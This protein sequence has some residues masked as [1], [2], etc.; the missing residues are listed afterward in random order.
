M[1]LG[2]AEPVSDGR[3]TLRWMRAEDVAPCA[4]AFRD[5]PDLGSRIGVERDPDESSLR[6]RIA[7]QQ[8]RTAEGNSIQLAIADADSGA[9]WGAMFL[10]SF[11]WHN[12]RAE[13]GFWLIPAVRGRGVG[14]A[15]VR[16]AISWAFETYDLLRMEMTTTPDNPAVP[17]LARR[18]SFTQEGV[19]RARNVERGRRV[20]I[21]WF[22]LLREEWLPGDAG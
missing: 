18:L 16:L 2:L 21:V 7:G 12:R 13:I 1:K 4:Q 19:L 5:D 22:G 6:E 11:D 8:E 14:V 3:V 20:D 15:A 17:A 9:F 10:H